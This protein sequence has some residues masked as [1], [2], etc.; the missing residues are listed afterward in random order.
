MGTVYKS[1]YRTEL[2]RLGG[3]GRSRSKKKKDA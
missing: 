2:V 1:A 3:V